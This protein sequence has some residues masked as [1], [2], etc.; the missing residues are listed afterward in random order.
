MEKKEFI[1]FYFIL[2]GFLF[3][4]AI[5]ESVQLYYSVYPRVQSVIQYGTEDQ[6]EIQRVNKILL[7]KVSQLTAIDPNEKVLVLT[8]DNVETLRAANDLNAEVYKNAQNGDRVLGFS[9]R[10]IIYR[11]EANSI[12]Y[13]GKSPVQLQQDAYV[14]ELKAVVSMIGK[15]VTLD[16]TLTPQFMIVNDPEVL[17]K[18]NVNIYKNAIKGDYVLFYSN[19]LIIYRPATK[20]IIYDGAPN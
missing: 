10:M 3:I 9:D 13:E 1:R 4:I 8:I 2:F 12:V 18:Q 20:T 5:L 6:I 11:E 7:K 19:R 14:K 15:S 17:K 16:S